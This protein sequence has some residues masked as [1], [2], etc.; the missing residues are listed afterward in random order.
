MEFL[1]VDPLHSL[2]VSIHAQKG[3]FAL[4]L[5]SG[6]SRAARIPTGWEVMLDLASKL[7]KVA[8]ENVEGEAAAK[9]YKTKYGEELG[10]SRLLDEL[11][12]TPAERQQLLRGFFEPTEE[13]AQQGIKSP[14]AAHRAIAALVADGYVRVFVTT[15]FDRLIERAIA[16]TGIAPTVIDWPD[17]VAGALPLVHSPCTVL[18]VHGD[19]LDT[20]LKNT[21]QELSSYEPEI[22]AL[23]NRIFDEYGLIVV[24]WSAQW[25]VA[26]RTALKRRN[27]RRFAVYWVNRGDPTDEAK[28]V[29]D[30]CQGRFVSSLGADAFFTDLREKVKALEDLALSDPLPPAVAAATVKR[31]L[32][33]DRFR[34]RLNDLVTNAV[35]S[36]AER[37]AV[38][39]FNMAQQFSGPE[40]LRRLNAYQ[41]ETDVL[42]HIVVPLCQWGTTVHETCVVNILELATNYSTLGIGMFIDGWNDLRRFPALLLFYAGGLAALSAG[43]YAML[44]ALLTRPRYH[45]HN[46]DFPLSLALSPRDVFGNWLR[47]ADPQ[48]NRSFGSSVYLSRFLRSLF[49]DT[50]PQQFRYDAAFDRFE[51]LFALVCADF[52][53]KDKQDKGLWNL[54]LAPA[55]FIFRNQ[56]APQ[57]TLK[58]VDQEVR[59]LGNNWPPLKAGLFDGNVGR[60]N[61]IKNGFD[62]LVAKRRAEG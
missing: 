14:T 54:E 56:G 61:D 41:A 16:D 53:E 58:I 30:F 39:N 26:L 22:N 28:S 37:I 50:V 51:Y 46:R 57:D 5:G 11:T 44:A 13:E 40:F 35:R 60:F 4:L 59:T 38:H 6:V 2:A 43:N 31:Y 10:Y 34:I 32:A 47:Q 21:E 12:A 55:W 42:R 15:N 1:N 24:G 23:L 49:S 9:W 62:R 52:Y 25:D 33:E 36:A 7:A 3:V 20:R 29:V 19:Y 18:K 8:G 48:Y 27:S 17:A 45:D